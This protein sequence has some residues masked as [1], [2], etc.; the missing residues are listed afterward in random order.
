MLTTRRLVER[1]AVSL[2][3][4]GGLVLI[5]HAA[6]AG[7]T[8]NTDTLS[9]SWTFVSKPLSMCVDFTVVGNI[10]YKATESPNRITSFEL[11]SIHLND[12]VLKAVVHG[13][14]LNAGCLAEKRRVSKI[15]IGQHWAGFACS[16][17]PS[18][19]VAIPWGVAAS[20]WPTCGSRKQGSYTTSYGAGARF[21]QNNTGSPAT[22][23]NVYS[24]GAKPKDCYG[25]FVSAEIFK[26]NKSDSY[27]DGQGAAAKQ[28]CLTPNYKG[29]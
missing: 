4:A 22:F 11:K 26:G 18:I 3:V 7:T 5:P 16:D 21:T 8:S 23:A 27:A 10:T 14:T 13:W 19:S 20:A 12:P 15:S 6:S 29:N 2:T 25:V 1:I 17:N 9:K 28:I 24:Q